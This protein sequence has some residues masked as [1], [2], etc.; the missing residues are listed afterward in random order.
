MADEFRITLTETTSISGTTVFIPTTT[1]NY[2]LRVDPFT[3]NTY[4]GT[5]SANGSWTF[6]TVADGVYQLW[7]ATSQVASFGQIFIMDNTPTFTNAYVATGGAL[8]TDT[9]AEYTA[10]TGV[11]IDGIL[12]KDSLNTSGIVAKTGTQTGIAGAK[13]WTGA[14][15]YW[16]GSTFIINS[17]GGGATNYPIM[18]Y[19]DGY[20]APATDYEVPVKKY[21]DDAVAGVSVSSFQESPNKVRVIVGGTAEAGKVY[22]TCKTAISYFSSPGLSKQCQVE[23]VGT[24]ITSE[25]IILSHADLVSYVHLK[26]DKHINL[27][28]G[29]TGASTTKTM[30][31]KGVT[32]Y[33]G[34]GDIVRAR[35]YNSFTF[36]NCDIYAYNSLTFTNCRLINC[37][38][39]QSS[40]H[41]ITA[42]GTT[43]MINCVAMQ[44]ITNSLTTGFI[45]NTT[46]GVM[47]SYS[48]PSDP[49]SGS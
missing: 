42:S 8:Y 7:N 40:A 45:A 30:T 16:G 49:T 25:Y 3:T 24:G 48:M 13:T 1:G 10:G 15:T 14:Q 43:E 35:T 2:Y 29:T 20:V 21:V 11:T 23:I 28:L 39:Y 5:H 37:N 17:S 33:F 4:T 32:L 31:I 9:I 27:I 18:S 22:L 36:E 44:G 26:G 38:I 12:L 41:G 46:D 19:S 47:T 34:N 6:G